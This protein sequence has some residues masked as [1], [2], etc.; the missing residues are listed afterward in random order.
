M[1]EVS[2]NSLGLFGTRASQRKHSIYR[3]SSNSGC[4][5]NYQYK[6]DG[7]TVINQRQY[8]ERNLVKALNHCRLENMKKLIEPSYSLEVSNI[9]DIFFYISLGLLLGLLEKKNV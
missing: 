7:Y 5:D 1:R 6:R 8:V 9:G 4:Q 3:K 2:L